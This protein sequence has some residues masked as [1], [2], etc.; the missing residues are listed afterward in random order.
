MAVA[1][2]LG[3]GLFGLAYVLI[4]GWQGVATHAGALAVG[5]LA[6]ILTGRSRIRR[7]EQSI[8]GTWTQWMRY[9]MA[10]DSLPEIFRKV[11]GRSGRNLPILY[12][13]ILTVVWGAEVGLIVLAVAGSQSAGIAFAGPV[14]AFN[15]LLAGVLVGHFAVIGRWMTT[16]GAS[17]TELVQSGEINVWGLA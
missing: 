10:A 5:V 17:V 11:R 12:A 7:Y 1:S 6:G 4:P 15:G 2:I 3:I 14:L 13:A 16:F 9:A 8:R